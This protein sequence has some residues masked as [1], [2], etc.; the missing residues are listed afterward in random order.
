[1]S[2]TVSNDDLLARSDERR[3]RALRIV[4][5]LGLLRRWSGYG[6]PILVG[7]VARGLVV[8]PDIDLE[9]YCDQPRIEDG[10]AVVT[11]LALVPGVRH[12]RFSN[13]LDSPDQGLYW[14]L[15]VG[16]P[17]SGPAETWKVD[18]WQLA[19]DHPGP[20]GRDLIEPMRRA[21]TPETRLAILT[22]K[23]ATIL[24]GRVRSIDIYRAVFDGGARSPAD[25][26]AWFA[27]HGPSGLTDWRP[28]PRD[29]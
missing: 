3:Q 13:E 10:F 4:E 6:E 28:A 18:M 11:E 29:A 23:E 27:R 5:S 1:M 9:I 8:K 12:V 17:T 7:G 15:R 2:A 25:F 26:E 19:H 21:L 20:R 22:I 14:Q 16:D 24:D